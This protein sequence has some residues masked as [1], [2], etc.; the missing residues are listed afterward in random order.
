METTAFLQIFRS[1]V[2]VGMSLSFIIK[3]NFSS[4]LY[5]SWDGAFTS[6]IFR[7]DDKTS[8][9]SIILFWKLDFHWKDNTH[10]STCR[11]LM[12]N[13]SVAMSCC[14]PS[15]INRNSRVSNR[16]NTHSERIDI[17]SY[18]SWSDSDGKRLKYFHSRA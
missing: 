4:C 10:E 11:T 13:A 16:L 8:A 12:N 6:R 14:S 15:W 17:S 3:N 7:I 1:D 5:H 2:V 18:A 9:K